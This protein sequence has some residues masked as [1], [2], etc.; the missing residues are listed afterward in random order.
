[1]KSRFS[2]YY[3]PTDTE[4]AALWRDCILSI[5]ANVLLNLYRYTKPT[6][7]RLLEILDRLKDRLWLTNQAA[8]EFHKNRL[9]VISQQYVAYDII[10]NDLNKNLTDLI[11]RVQQQYPKHSGLDMLALE[12]VVK[13]TSE[14]L[15]SILRSAKA[16]HPDLMHDDP[17]LR[18]V[19]NLFDSAVGDPYSVVELEKKRKEAQARFDR[20]DPP[21][22]EDA[23]T[24]GD[25]GK[26]GDAL[27]WFQLL[28]YAQGQQ[29]PIIFITDD[30]KDD[31][32]HIHRGQ[33]LGPRPELVQEMQAVAD[34]RFYMYQPEH[35]IRRAE[36][37]LHLPKQPAVIE[38]VKEVSRYLMDLT[39]SR[40]RVSGQGYNFGELLVPRGR[41]VPTVFVAL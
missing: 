28:E 21:G 3:A 29:K 15:A 13:G 12:K 20:K 4:F 7:D 11:V 31:W 39:D 25:V 27:V 30:R 33:T 19:T 2:G 22:Y 8:H 41:S 23:K 17:I 6:S 36:T 16:K 10:A 18:R 37:F 34:V 35:F 5:D 26:Y 9:T 38:E 14:R 32:W 40:D 24:K 1:M